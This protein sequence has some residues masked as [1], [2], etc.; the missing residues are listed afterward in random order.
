MNR[1]EFGEKV[2]AAAQ[3]YLSWLDP[4]DENYDTTRTAALAARRAGLPVSPESRWT[5]EDCPVA[6]AVICEA[7]DLRHGRA[8]YT[9]D[10]AVDAAFEEYRL[11]YLA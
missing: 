4:G 3:T 8:T 1:H 6:H 11:G 9:T 10:Y 7:C 2:K 5:A